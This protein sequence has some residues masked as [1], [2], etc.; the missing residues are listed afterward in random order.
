M[1]QIKAYIH[2]IRSAAVIEGLCD[3]SYKNLALLD[4]KGTLHALCESEQKFSTEA[5]VIISE[6]QI[7]LVCE[8]HQV[9]EVSQIIKK[10]A[11]IGED[12]SGWIYISSVDKAI[13]IQ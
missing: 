4:V 6:V 9:D 2:H 5:G 1:K 7:V 3:A 12:I 8:D 13:A 11:K 10:H